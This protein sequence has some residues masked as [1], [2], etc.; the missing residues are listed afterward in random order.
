MPITLV[1]R[2]TREMIQRNPNTLFVFGDNYARVGFG[3]QAQAARGEPNAV[4][5]VTK[6]SPSR[7][8]SDEDWDAVKPLIV[9]A[10]AKLAAH[11]E[12]GGNIV[13]PVDGVGTGLARLEEHAPEIASAIERCRLYLFSS[14]ER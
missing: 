2:Y 13:W 1:H 11:L 10:F 6:M 12:K 14:I 9:R 8:C 5:I 3:G 7:Y 4:G